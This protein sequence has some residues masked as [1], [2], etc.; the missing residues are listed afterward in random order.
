MGGKTGVD[1][2]SG[3]NLAGAFKQPRLVVADT[4]TLQSLPPVEWASGSA[5]VA[6][7]AVI[8]GERF[9]R[10]LETNAARLLQR[11]AAVTAETVARCVRFKSGVVSTDEKEDGVRECLNYGHTLGHAIE[12]VAG[13]GVVPHGVAVAEGMRFAARLSVEAGGGSV[14]FVKRQDQLLD[15]MGLPTL[16]DGYPPAELLSAM[17]SDKKARGGKVRFVLAEAP[18]VWRCEAVADTMIAE[19]LRAWAASKARSFRVKRILVLNGPNLNL[20]GSREPAVYGTVGLASIESDLAALAEVLGVEVSFAQSNHEGEL[21]DLL[22]AAQGVYD[23]VVFNPGAF[24]HYS[25]ALRDAVAAI[26]T[27]VVEV[28]LSN[29]TARESFRRES[30]IVPACVGQISG[31]GPESYSLGMRAAVSSLT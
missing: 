29:I 8:S 31:F 27:P 9:L 7:S 15:A 25:Y 6:K 1:L 30:V 3:K 17:Q 18:G 21:I 11:D 28:H 14:G 26:D 5:E 12:K 10:W 13:Y 24:S 2:T 16:V 23:A 20:L 4:D 22:H 19:H